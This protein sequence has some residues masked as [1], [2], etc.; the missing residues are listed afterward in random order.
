M[1]IIFSRKGF[2][3]QNGGIPSPI[4]SDIPL[5]LP[6]PYIENTSV[7]FKDLKLSKLLKDLS[8]DRIDPLTTCHVDP[9]LELGAFGQVSASQSH[10]NNKKVGLG[11]LFL[12]FGRFREVEFTNEFYKWKR[13]SKPHHRIYGW[14]QVGEKINIGTNPENFCKRY[15]KFANHPHAT[16]KWKKNNTIY[17][18]CKKLEFCGIQSLNGFGRF[19][20]TSATLLSSNPNSGISIW[21][22]PSWLNPKTGGCG[23][24]YHDINRW[25]MTTVKTVSKGQE[26]VAKPK[27]SSELKNWLISLF[28]N[29]I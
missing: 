5:S 16:G 1:K 24:S 22:T 29:T 10:L 23:M 7:T 8:Q 12:F 18:S 28:D 25:G 27:Y 15:P 26:F 6:I 4:V 13:N 19:R 14:L 11:D 20:A 17:L 21:N 2:D 9:D 3:S